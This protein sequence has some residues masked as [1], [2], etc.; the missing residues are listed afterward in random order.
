M[1]LPEDPTKLT[2][3]IDLKPSRPTPPR[4]G[5][6]CSSPPKESQANNEAPR[7][8]P[9]L[10]RNPVRLPGR[11]HQQCGETGDGA[12]DRGEST[13]GVAKPA[14]AQILEN[15]PDLADTARQIGQKSQ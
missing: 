11:L 12:K 10:V 7:L 2:L 9:C 4:R 1:P 14:Q 5:C 8:H 15:R 3:R 6:R 13:H